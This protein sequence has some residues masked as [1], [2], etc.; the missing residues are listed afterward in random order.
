MTH[1]GLSTSFPNVSGFLF[2]VHLCNAVVACYY[3]C[4]SVSK[5][6]I[7]AFKLGFLLFSWVDISYLNISV[8]FELKISQSITTVLSICVS[9]R[10]LSEE[11]K[12][13]VFSLTHMTSRGPVA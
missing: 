3:L 11:L 6:Y 8:L 2:Y 5:F 10:K 13:V 9:V 12:S 7:L 1:K 4:L